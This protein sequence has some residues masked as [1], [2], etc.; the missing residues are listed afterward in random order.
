MNFLAWEEQFA[1][2]YK[3]GCV[4]NTPLLLYIYNVLARQVPLQFFL[5]YSI[6]T[7]VHPCMSGSMPYWISRNI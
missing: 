3:R 2:I 5:S 1:Q 4:Y 6:T 7:R